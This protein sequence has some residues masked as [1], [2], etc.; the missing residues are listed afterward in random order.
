MVHDVFLAKVG[1][2]FHEHPFWQRDINRRVVTK[3]LSW[4]SKTT[5]FFAYFMSAFAKN[6]RVFYEDA[7]FFDLISS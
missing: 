1:M 6:N 7:N 5:C 3:V 4:A 2:C